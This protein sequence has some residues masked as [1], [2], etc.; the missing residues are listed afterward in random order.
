MVRW[1]VTAAACAMVVGVVAGGWVIHA[2]SQRCRGCVNHAAQSSLRN[3]LA[4]AR[5]IYTDTDDYSEV[6]LK[7]MSS[8]ESSLT[9]TK[10]PS[11]GPDIVS[12]SVS[13]DPPMQIGLAAYDHS[14][15]CYMIHDDA[16]LGVRYG[17]SDSG[18][19]TGQ[20]ALSASDEWW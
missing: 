9:F 6:T 1:L 15:R 17:V 20:H 11:T 5:T 18:S 13:G 14:G 16:T 10:G 2:N 8:T 19:C 4:A 12:L 7:A 3:G